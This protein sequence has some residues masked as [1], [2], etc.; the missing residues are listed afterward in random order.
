MFG[1]ELDN[2]RFAE[3]DRQY[4]SIGRA[5]LMRQSHDWVSFGGGLSYSMLYS[6][7]T[8]V[9][10]PEIR[11]HQEVN[12][13]YGEDRFNFNHRLRIEQR[14][15]G[16]TLRQIKNGEVA[17]EEN[18]GTYD[19]TIRSRYM[20]SMD[21]VL[22]DKKEEKGHFNFETNAEIMVNDSIE[23]WLDTLRYYFGLKYFLSRDLQIHLGYLKSI[24]KEYQFDT[25]FDY[26]NIRF[27]LRHRIRKG[28]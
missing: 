3:A 16:D 2:R 8:S 12:F 15:V 13:S 18:L 11:P 26:E 20:L 14:F 5:S 21:F 27:T 24:E 10:Q 22:V 4:Q 19:F 17:I 23:E 28:D 9:I 7:F 25:L 1:L 6:L